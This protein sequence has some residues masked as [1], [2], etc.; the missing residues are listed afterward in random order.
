M[1]E[2][3]EQLLYVGASRAKYKLNI[4]ANLN[5]DKCGILLEK[6]GYKK[7]RKPYKSLATLFNSRFKK[8]E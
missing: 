1:R 7:D 6:Y 5:E 3:I 4:I 2:E 8:I